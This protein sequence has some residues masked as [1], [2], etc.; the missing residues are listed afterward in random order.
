MKYVCLGYIEK[1]KFE[2]MSEGEQHAMLDRCFEYDDHLRA[3]IASFKNLLD[4]GILWFAVHQH[5][6]EILAVQAGKASGK[7]SASNRFGLSEVLHK[8]NVTI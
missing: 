7:V 1:G 5:T 4:P 2:G 3:T 8:K 6:I